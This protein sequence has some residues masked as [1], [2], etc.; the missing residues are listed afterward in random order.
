MGVFSSNLN[1][2]METLLSPLQLQCRFKLPEKSGEIGRELREGRQWPI[3]A[4]L[5]WAQL[6][7]SR[8]E[9]YCSSLKKERD[10]F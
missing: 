4:E 3:V 9:F 5:F 10:T 8:I 7:Q 6:G 2:L 1:D